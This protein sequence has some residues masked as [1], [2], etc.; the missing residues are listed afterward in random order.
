M[1]PV[2]EPWLIKSTP[3]NLPARIGRGILLEL[4]GNHAITIIQSWKVRFGSVFEN[5]LVQPFHLPNEEGN[6]DAMRKTHKPWDWV[7]AI[8]AASAAAGEPELIL[9]H[10]I[11]D[12]GHINPAQPTFLQLIGHR[13]WAQA[14]CRREQ[15]RCDRNQPRVWDCPVGG[16]KC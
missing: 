6:G 16:H 15:P 14:K 3:W 9:L 10:D 2:T 11:C 4:M 5:P 13:I 8:P 1:C 7:P 12:L